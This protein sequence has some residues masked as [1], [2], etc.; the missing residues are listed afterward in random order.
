MPNGCCP[1]CGGIFVRW[2]EELSKSAYVI[3][4]R[5]ETCAHVWNVPK[6][7]PDAAPHH[8]TPL[9]AELDPE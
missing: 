5:C 3:Y 4:Y 8:V 9:L 2:L 7:D 6:D 1:I